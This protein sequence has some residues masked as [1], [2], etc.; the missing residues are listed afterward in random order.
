MVLVANNRV[1][2]GK[3]CSIAKSCCVAEK[4]QHIHGK[5][6]SG[7]LPYNMWKTTDNIQWQEKTGEKHRYGMIF[8]R[9]GGPGSEVIHNN[10]HTII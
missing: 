8:I 10:T 7:V 5:K 4:L 2:F 9:I 1:D 3:W 6:I